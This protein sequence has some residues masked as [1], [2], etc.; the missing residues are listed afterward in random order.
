MHAELIRQQPQQGDYW[1]IELALASPSPAP[2]IGTS[3]HWQNKQACLFQH[4][5]NRAQFL[6][7]APLPEPLDWTQ[8][9]WQQHACAPL[10][11]EHPQLWLATGLAQASVFAAAKHWQQHAANKAPFCALL[12][13]EQ[14]FAFTPKPARFV[15]PLANEAIGACALLEDWGV[16]NRLAHADGLPGCYEGQ[17]SA[18]YH[19][20]LTQQPTESCWHIYAFLP[21]SELTALA[22]LSPPQMT[23]HLYATDEDGLFSNAT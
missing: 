23:L 11:F 20:W 8:V 22:Q 14:A 4:Q 7:R 9:R 19:T 16:A 17:L 5:G 3:L 12:H 2:A 6:S 10:Q 1:L 15:W 21:H 18:L 13:S